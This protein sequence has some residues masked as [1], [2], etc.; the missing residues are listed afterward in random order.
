[1]LD[2]NFRNLN[3]N[4]AIDFETDSGEYKFWMPGDLQPPNQTPFNENWYRLD[5]ILKERKTN[6]STQLGT[7]NGTIADNKS[8]S[9]NKF[10][11]IT[12]QFNTLDTKVSDFRDLTFGNEY[13]DDVIDLKL[14][15]L[16][17]GTLLAAVE[18]INEDVKKRALK[19]EIPTDYVTMADVEAK[20]YLTSY[21]ETDPTVPA[22]AKEAT[23]PSYNSSEIIVDTANNK[24]LA[25]LI[26]EL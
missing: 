20:N 3:L 23:K 2:E 26:T 17:A 4:S 11:E 1:M 8:I 19:S 16:K 15:N 14:L 9:D 24:S 13:S 10:N 22:W 7:L 18:L 21:T 12:N 6:F 25:T 5:K